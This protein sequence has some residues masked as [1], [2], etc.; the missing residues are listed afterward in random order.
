MGRG[1]VCHTRMTLQERRICTWGAAGE[2]DAP[3]G[4]AAGMAS[5]ESSASKVLT[6]D[7]AGLQAGSLPAAEGGGLEAGVEEAPSGWPFFCPLSE[8]VSCM[9]YSQPLHAKGN[10]KK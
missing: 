8:G 4:G 7:G 9:S 2:E 3:T 5:S 6:S 1:G 10:I